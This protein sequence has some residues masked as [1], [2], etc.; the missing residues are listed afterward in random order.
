MNQTLKSSLIALAVIGILL[1]SIAGLGE[2]RK[3]EKS[4]NSPEP[5]NDGTCTSDCHNLVPFAKPT[6]SEKS[7]DKWVK[8][9]IPRP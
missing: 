7:F 9:Q 8:S 1:G 6:G 3:Y 2:F 4:L 5:Y